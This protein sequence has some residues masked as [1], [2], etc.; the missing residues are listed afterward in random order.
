MSL[1]DISDERTNLV[2]QSRNLGIVENFRFLYDLSAF[3]ILAIVPG[4]GEW[5]PSEMCGLI[6]EFGDRL[7]ESILLTVRPNRFPN[8][9][10]LRVTVS[11]LYTGVHP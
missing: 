6:G 11:V 10:F 1:I 2:V 5:P 3:E 9:S 7:L 8:Y 4:D